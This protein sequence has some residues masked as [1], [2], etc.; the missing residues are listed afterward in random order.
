M[1][2]FPVFRA[3]NFIAAHVHHGFFGR[4]RPVHKGP[5]LKGPVDKIQS[6]ADNRT[7]IADQMGIPIA[8]LI[9]VHQIHSAAAIHVEGPWKTQPPKADAMV[10]KTPG[11]ALSLVTA[12]CAPIL[13]C[14]AAA[15]IIGAAHAGWRG[16]HDG[17]IAATVTAMQNLGAEPA[18]INAAIGPCIAQDSYEV[19]PELLDHFRTL[20]ADNQ[21]FF[22]HG[23][24]DRWQFDLKAY[25]HF[26]LK[27]TGIKTI[28][29][30]PH[31]TYGEESTF[32]S[33]RR[34]TQRGESDYGRN[35]SVI[36]LR[37]G[38]EDRH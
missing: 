5:V 7:R 24:E 10:S 4:E 37:Q 38:A 18:N 27:E 25:C 28:E 8:N 14:D 12:D 34:A 3:K 30:L 29:I 22:K 21:R 32:F 9:N 35:I 20:N 26:Q 17:I 31:D 19:G 6:T 13:L 1:S 11:L 16:A 36:H 23:R 33:Y 2:D 15:G